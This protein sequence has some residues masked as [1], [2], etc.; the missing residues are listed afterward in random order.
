MMDTVDIRSAV[1]DDSPAI[2][3]LSTQLGYSTPPIQSANRLGVILDSNEH[4]ILVACLADGA[5]VGWL[6]VFLAFRVQ[7]DQFA[8]IGGF[9]VTKEFRRQGI[10]RCLL[11]SAERWVIHSGITKLRVRSRSSRPDTLTFYERFGFSKS[12]QQH[13]FDK[14]LKTN[15]KHRGLVDT[16]QRRH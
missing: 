2:A 10:G 8:E 11:A 1:L 5:L 7:T 6:H 16:A 3:D 4:E 13:V 14:S 9:V 12:K 15:A